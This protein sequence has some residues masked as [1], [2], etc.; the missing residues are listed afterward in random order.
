MP[1][2]AEASTF[3]H[4]QDGIRAGT[5]TRAT[6][7]NG[8]SG[9]CSVTVDALSFE[10]PLDDRSVVASSVTLSPGENDVAFFARIIAMVASS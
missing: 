9:H 10:K 4:E 1:T 8:A 7:G 6:G 5:A 3:R 2:E